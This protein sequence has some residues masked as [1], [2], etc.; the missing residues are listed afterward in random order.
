[1][2]AQ[3][4]KKLEEFGITNKLEQAHFLAQ[5]SH[6]SQ[7]FTKFKEGENYRF[8]RAK[9]IWSTR[10]DI[11][12][13][14]Q[15]SLE[16]SDEDFCPQ[17]WLFNTM[18]G[19]RMGN[20][21]L[22]D[23]YNFRGRGIFQLTGK[24][25]YKRFNEWLYIQ[26]KSLKLPLED[27]CKFVETE[28]GAILSAIFFWLTNKIGVVARADNLISVCKI[29]NGGVIGLDKRKKELTRFKKLLNIK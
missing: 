2:M 15:F 3:V 11:I 23:G 7:N 28:N 14:K 20:T 16:K 17:P 4:I 18:Y 25:N 19:N 8:K 12:E 10:A 27:A 13:L 9:I 5:A 26:N 6:E 29:I 22:N 1:M 21:D 24:F